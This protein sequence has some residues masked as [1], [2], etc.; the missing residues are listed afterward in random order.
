MTFLVLMMPSWRNKAGVYSTAHLVFL[1]EFYVENITKKSL[2][3]EAP[4]S[5]SHGW[6]SIL[7]RRDMFKSQLGKAIGDGKETKVWSDPWLSLSEP[8][9]PMGPEPYS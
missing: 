2:S 4:C 6:L 5:A 9:K 1:L 7:I 8:K 3:L